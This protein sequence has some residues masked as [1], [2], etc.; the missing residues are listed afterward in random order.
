LRV[1]NPT[2]LGTIVMLTTRSPRRTGVA[3]IRLSG[4]LAA[5]AGTLANH[6]HGRNA[7][8]LRR[9]VVGVILAHDLNFTVKHLQDGF[10]QEW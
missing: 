10:E 6:I 1:E 4:R 2:P 9:L 7:W 8:R 5:W 3:Q